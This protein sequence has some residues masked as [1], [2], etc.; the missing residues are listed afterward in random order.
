M[1]G[2]RAAILFLVADPDFVNTVSLVFE[3][4]DFAPDRTR[5]LLVTGE[6][7]MSL[8][9]SRNAD[10]FALQAT[11]VAWRHSR[12][13]W[14]REDLGEISQRRFWAGP[15]DR[16][17]SVGARGSALQYD[18]F[19]WNPL[20]VEADVQYFDVH[21]HP[22]HGVFACGEPGALHRLSDD[23]WRPVELNRGD[24]FRGI[25]VA[26]DGT[27]RLASDDGVCIRVADGEITELK[28]PDMTFFSV[29]RYRD[30]YF[31][32][33]ETGVFVEQANELVPFRETGFAS[34]LRS[35]GDFLY[36][37]GAG[38]AWRFDGAE[39]KVLTLRYDAGF[40]LD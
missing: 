21:G 14:F 37:A 25:D 6:W 29:R 16:L 22:D 34:D 1:F 24:R 5:N 31:W 28:A 8:S 11:T 26:P 33:A 2:R 38:T 36:V 40:F 3:T 39:W 19:R 17:L 13:G 12:D 30:R 35:D 23:R 4:E 15:A 7:L 27:V 10:L 32:G 20:A 9:A 18:G